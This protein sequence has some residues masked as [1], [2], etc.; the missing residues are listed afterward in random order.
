MLAVLGFATLGSFMLLV[1]R[2]HLS[3]FTAIMLTRLLLAT[4]LRRTRPA[5]LP[6]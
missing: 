5:A 2:K 1:M 6:V 3:A 4:W